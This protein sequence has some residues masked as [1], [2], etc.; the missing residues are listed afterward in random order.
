MTGSSVGLFLASLL[1]QGI[2]MH[3][4]KGTSSSRPPQTIPVRE[5]EAQDLV[6]PRAMQKGAAG[7]KSFMTHAEISW[8][9]A[10]IAVPDAGA[11]LAVTA[12]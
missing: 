12:S 5:T 6:L 4:A 11:T 3:I 10:F 7:K 8:N 1:S 9:Q 2:L